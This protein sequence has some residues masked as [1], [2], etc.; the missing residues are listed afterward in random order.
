[1]SEIIRP[2]E[3]EPDF[4]Y[5]SDLEIEER[6]YFITRGILEAERRADGGVVWPE[7]VLDT[8]RRYREA[9]HRQNIYE[10]EY[11]SIIIE[12]MLPDTSELSLDLLYDMLNVYFWWNPNKP[13]P[14]YVGMF[15]APG[16]LLEPLLCGLNDDQF[17][18]CVRLMHDAFSE[19][20][21]VCRKNGC[22]GSDGYECL[23]KRA[24]KMT[25]YKLSGSSYETLKTPSLRAEAF[26]NLMSVRKNVD[27]EF[28][29][30]LNDAIE[31]H[32][33]ARLLAAG[34]DEMEA[35]DS[36]NVLAYEAERRV[37]TI[38]G[39]GSSKEFRIDGEHYTEHFHEGGNVE[40]FLEYA[41]GVVAANDHQF[42]AMMWGFDDANDLP[43]NPLGLPLD[44]KIEL[45]RRALFS[46]QDRYELLEV[47]RRWK[48]EGALPHYLYRFRP[49]F[50]GDI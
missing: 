19:N 10:R 47:S 1:M 41:S 18:A 21:K 24:P 25:K 9:R 40:S 37:L 2:E 36:P 39:Y 49:V 16:E 42:N 30:S 22:V 38:P 45:A 3:N 7:S 26:I 34:L 12:R 43:E 13:M 23:A 20:C 29:D 44:T 46:E 35:M 28:L 8:D 31:Q 32:N 6:N 11:T 15:E 4:A 17:A 27:S 50:G 48:E 14:G 5:P 33:V